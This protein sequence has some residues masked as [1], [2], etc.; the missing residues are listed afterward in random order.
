MI[1]DLLS[2]DGGPAGLRAPQAGT[3]H[4]S[5]DYTLAAGDALG[6]SGPVGLKLEV[7]NTG[8]ITLELD[9]A[10][11]ATAGGGQANVSAI[12]TSASHHGQ[13]DIELASTATLDVSAD[14]GFAVGLKL[15][16]SD[17]R[18][19]SFATV[20]VASAQDRAWFVLGEA[21]GLNLNSLGQVSVTAGREAYGMQVYGDDAQ[22]VNDGT[23]SVT[24]RFAYG[25][26]LIGGHEFFHN[27]GV[28]AARGVSHDGFALGAQVDGGQVFNDGS[29]VVHGVGAVYGVTLDGGEAFINSG[30]IEVSNHG[31]APAIA[32]VASQ[33]LGKDFVNDGLIK[34][35]MAIA[36]TGGGVVVDGDEHWTNFGQVVGGV[37]LGDHDDSFA[38]DGLVRGDIDLGAGQDLFDGHGGKLVG[39]VYGGQGD[40]ILIGGGKV[41]HLVGDDITG[42][43]GG[44]DLL[45]GLGGADILDGGVG[46]DTL[47]GGHGSDLL[48]GGD[49]NDTFVF[50]LGDS[51]PVNVDEIT[52]LSAGDIIDLSR[53]DADVGSF[54]D[55]GFN[56]VAAFSGT[57][58]ELTVSY[59]SG[60]GRTFIQ[61]DTD[62]DG[63]EDVIIA[64]DG[65]HT[66]FS[67]FV[68]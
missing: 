63:F 5:S 50:R 61:G 31:G 28:I 39:A 40:D 25:V 19:A 18:L 66:G 56:I 29:I 43:A 36:S 67:N 6:L 57:A 16:A 17:T 12:V 52:D 68:L 26:S 32:V 59:D 65:D 30:S 20:D 60:S 24:G 49:G 47:F 38:N 21:D 15:L 37:S 3:L 11:T 23:I 2:A 51:G 48:T 42:P 27:T 14:G 9:G 33:T 22:A 62:G 10:V 64:A 58:G 35:T 34:G 46:D 55:Q 41:D 7:R 53:I 45:R 54:G 4:V 13:A 44:Q 1:S 8:P